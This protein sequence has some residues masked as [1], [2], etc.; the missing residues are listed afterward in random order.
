MVRASQG[1]RDLRSSVRRKLESSDG[2]EL[3]RSTRIGAGE[4]IAFEHVREKAHHRG[5]K[6]AGQ[7]DGRRLGSFRG[8]ALN[9]RNRRAA[10]AKRYGSQARRKSGER[11]RWQGKE[12]PGRR[13][14]AT[15]DVRGRGFCG[16]GFP[17]RRA[18][19]VTQPP[20]RRQALRRALHPQTRPKLSRLKIATSRD[21]T[22]RREPSD[23]TREIDSAR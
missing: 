21:G 17:S 14:R 12:F 23:P 7:A 1:D 9:Q 5:R 22:P 2:G 20:Q 16:S 3:H 8:R 10:L 4:Q 6:I 19:E 15:G 13:R 11:G 18:Q